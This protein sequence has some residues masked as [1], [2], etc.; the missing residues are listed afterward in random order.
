MRYSLFDKYKKDDLIQIEN[1]DLRST[2]ENNMI[3]FLYQEYGKYIHA[4]KGDIYESSYTD[5]EKSTGL[6]TNK[7]LGITVTQARYAL[8]TVSP[9][10]PLDTVTNYWLYTK[11]NDKLVLAWQKT[12]YTLDDGSVKTVTKDD[13]NIT[14]TMLFR[15]SKSIPTS[16]SSATIAGASSSISNTMLVPTPTLIKKH[17]APSLMPAETP[18][19]FFQTIIN[20]LASLFN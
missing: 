1:H 12:E 19:N 4:P 17:F 11:K 2:S 18:Q 5:V 7:D 10:S 20:F 3:T 8:P 15:G 6:L 14:A 13:K 16:S 9:M